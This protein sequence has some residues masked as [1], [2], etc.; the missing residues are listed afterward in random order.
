MHGCVWK[1]RYLQPSISLSQMTRFPRQLITLDRLMVVGMI[2]NIY[3]ELQTGGAV[4]GS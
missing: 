2:L 1:V 4:A 3:Q